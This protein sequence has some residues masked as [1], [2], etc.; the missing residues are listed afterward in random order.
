MKYKI[1]TYIKAYSRHLFSIQL[2][3]LIWYWLTPKKIRCYF[4]AAALMEYHETGQAVAN[5]DLLD[6]AK[7]LVEQ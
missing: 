7:V 1:R 5:K 4:L 6:K 2:W 3:A